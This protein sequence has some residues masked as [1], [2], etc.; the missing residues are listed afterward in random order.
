M[1]WAPRITFLGYD[2]PRRSTLTIVPCFGETTTRTAIMSRSWSAVRLLRRSCR[3][4]LLSRVRRAKSPN[5]RCDRGPTGLRGKSDGLEEG[6][7]LAE[8]HAR[9][10][11]SGAIRTETSSTA[12]RLMQTPASDATEITRPLPPHRPLRASCLVRT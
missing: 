3:D 10:V 12:G 8:M 11:E 2:R 4:S 7:R 6:H 9:R 5:T 1:N